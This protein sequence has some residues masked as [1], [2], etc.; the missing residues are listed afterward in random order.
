MLLFTII[1][2]IAQF[3]LLSVLALATGLGMLLYSDAGTR[4]TLGILDRLAGDAVQFSEVDGSLLRG[5]TLSGTLVRTETLE[6]ALQQMSFRWEPIGLLRRELQIP[7]LQI[8]NLRVIVYRTGTETETEPGALILPDAL[9]LPIGFDLGRLRI[10]NLQVILEGQA[11]PVIDFI[12]LSAMATER[13]IQLRSLALEI[14]GAKLAL[15]GFIVLDGEF[16]IRVDGSWHASVPEEVALRLMHKEAE[17]RFA[18]TG[19]LRSRLELRHHLDA[20][21][22]ITSAGKIE[23]P[24]GAAS[25]TSRH[26]WSALEVELDSG[27]RLS[28]EPGSLELSGT[29]QAWQANIQT[30][31]ASA[32]WPILEIRGEIHGDP[33]LVRLDRLALTADQG[34]ID[35]WGH[36][37]LGGSMPFALSTQASDLNLSPLWPDGSPRIDALALHILG[38]H[39]AD[40]GQLQATL[41][42]VDMRGRMA[43]QPLQ[44]TGQVAARGLESIAMEMIQ[45]VVGDNRVVVNG[46]LGELLQLQ[47][48]LDGPD[49]ALLAP[50]LSGQLHAAG[51]LRGSRSEP[52]LTASARFRNLRRDEI[53]LGS[54][55]IEI[56]AGLALQDPF[57]IE[58]GV[59]DAAVGDIQIP[60]LR[61]QAN[62]KAS[63]HRIT[64]H[65]QAMDRLTTTLQTEG[66]YASD[67][68][69]WSGVFGS[70]DITDRDFGRWQL[71]ESTRVRAS[72]S[73]AFLETLCLADGEARIC[74]AGQWD[75]T[76]G[77]S[78][79]GTLEAFDLAR[80]E[81]WWPDSLTISGVL[82]ASF[83]TG[84]GPD[85]AITAA[86]DLQPMSGTVDYVGL[87]TE[88]ISLGYHDLALT[89]RLNEGNLVGILG[90]DFNAM[91]NVDARIEAQLDAPDIPVS[92]QGHLV[93]QRLDWLG[94]LTDAIEDPAGRMEVDLRLAGTLKNPLPSGHL[95]LHSAQV[96]I[97]ETGLIFTAP[98]LALEFD[99]SAR[100]IFSGSILS[101][102]T[103]LSLGGEIRTDADGPSVTMNLFGLDFHVV[104]RE[105]VQAWVS[106]NLQLTWSTSEALRIRGSIVVPRLRINAPEVPEGAI[107]VSA[108][109]YF[110]EEEVQESAAGTGVDLRIRII[111]GDDVRFDGFGLLARFFGEIDL[112][113]PENAPLQAFGEIVIV[114]GQYRSYG[115]DLRIDRGSLVFQGP[116]TDPGLDIRAERRIRR[117]EV[118]VGVQ[119]GGTVSQLRSSLFSEPPM[120]DTEALSFLLTGR[121]LGGTSDASTGQL[122]A[123]AATGWG[124]DQ[125]AVITQRLGRDL[126]LTELDLDTDSDEFEGGALIVGQQ[127]SPRLMLRYSLGLFE[128]GQ[129]L[130][131][132]YE[133][134]ESLRLETSSTGTQQGADLIYRIER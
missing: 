35:A 47:W 33:H 96:G 102:E 97:P 109:E 49:L 88:D 24:L 21:I 103:S 130:T 26:E 84:Q 57:Q 14:D 132:E 87:P 83:A 40:P 104:A 90:V 15:E 98:L 17:G 46:R 77:A 119:I 106:P 64:V 125:A 80:L 127:L 134:T 3:L 71:A 105:D 65:A 116:L 42:I 10:D 108:D 32:D 37:E 8:R 91:G 63:A 45:V 29:A 67:R 20:G 121:P 92:G 60:K 38:E 23:E 19:N 74:I 95:R 9:S 28:I 93:L 131:L 50:G 53:A 39:P 30:A 25:L 100:G 2:R 11:Q 58:I 85:G 27:E 113:Q 124:L 76:R 55:H 79:N 34:R 107:T 78:M 13:E 12:E 94:F 56:D 43:G 101:G 6:V 66:S 44:I 120:D 72:P 7:D 111:L 110:P 51:E 128:R 82:A 68:R 16:P 123:N 54:G 114:E 99:D 69:E 59:D 112:T 89:L 117:P 115:Q 5:L 52:R 4:W 122:L 36:L 62:G 31:I 126:G 22:L 61:I 75:D 70:I 81:A 118:V 129:K 1:G 86:L 18:L 41:E 73:A 133:L 48:E